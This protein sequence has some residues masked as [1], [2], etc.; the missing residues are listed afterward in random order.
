[1]ESKKQLIST[2]ITFL[3]VIFSLNLKSYGS[4][5]DTV[6]VVVKTQSYN[7]LYE[8]KNCVMMWIQKQ[9]KTYIKTILKKAAKRIQHCTLWN[10]ISKGDVDGLTGATRS[11]H[12][13]TL[14]GIWDCT[15]QDGN[16][17]ENGDYEFWV[18]M[19]ENN[20]TGKSSFG[21][22]TI[23]GT[24]LTVNGKTTSEFPLLKAIYTRTVSVK[25]TKKI[26]KNDIHFAYNKSLL[27]FEFPNSGIYSISII[28]PEGKL[29]AAKKGNGLKASV[30]LDD[31]QL[32]TGVYLIKISQAGRNYTIQHLFGF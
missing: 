22:I 13:D 14:T 10:S 5:G 18:E 23:G 19:T 26:H 11:N 12:D 6:K 29:L 31:F 9:D 4:S 2:I 16:P 32:K 28:S 7:G 25:G 20:A 27:S 30:P 17:V 24:G 8:P 3:I 21:S 1:M 15:D